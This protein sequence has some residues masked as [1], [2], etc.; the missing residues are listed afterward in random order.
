MR[1]LL[2]NRATGFYFRGVADWTKDLG[3][4]FDFGTPE[5]A[6]RFVAAAC[7]NAREMELILAFKDPRYNVP[8]PLDERYGVRELAQK[9]ANPTGVD[10]TW[11]AVAVLS[12]QRGVEPEPRFVPLDP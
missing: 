3:I 1:T 12:H 11:T 10:R 6:A 9:N 7:L 8:L 4:A 5:R 2:R